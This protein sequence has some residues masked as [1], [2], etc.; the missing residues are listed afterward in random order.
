MCILDPGW[1]FLGHDIP[2]QM[3]LESRTAGKCARRCQQLARCGFFTYVWGKC[4]LKTSGIGR[5]GSADSN[6]VSGWCSVAHHVDPS[7]ST[8]SP[9][10]AG[11]GAETHSEGEDV[12]TFASTI[13]RCAL[14]AGFDYNGHD[15]PRWANLV[16]ANATHCA[17]LCQEHS[18]CS[19]FSYVWGRCYL[20]TSDVG[21]RASS[22]VHAV[23]GVC[24]SRGVGAP[25]R[26]Q[27][28]GQPDVH[29]SSAGHVKL[30]AGLALVGR[31]CCRIGPT[32]V[33][34]EWFTAAA[35]PLSTCMRF[36]EATVRCG[37]V[38]FKQQ[39]SGRVLCKFASV[40]PHSSWRANRNKACTCFAKL[41]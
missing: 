10:S 4:F 22:D 1:N 40:Y 34:P 8:T 7:S 31:G 21:R 3:H 32:N 35:L 39:A 41:P 12:T 14:D 17:S 27:L 24:S 5:A 20:K 38:E 11:N 13:T 18:G 37:G 30:A 33:V 2:G 9:A 6:S 29:L 28:L 19:F 23:S 36:C 26:P 25:D 15:I 16:V